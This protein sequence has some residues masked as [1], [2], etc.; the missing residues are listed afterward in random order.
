MKLCISILNARQTTHSNPT[1]YY[2]LIICILFYLHI[3]LFTIIFI[4][5]RFKALIHN[6][7]AQ[8]FCHYAN[9]MVMLKGK[10]LPDGSMVTWKTTQRWVFDSG[11][12]L[13]E[14]FTES[15]LGLD[16]TLKKSALKIKENSFV[17]KSDRPLC[18]SAFEANFS[19]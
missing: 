17:L 4:P 15:E 16:W 13:G 11:G 14:I 18:F 3:I 7:M 12:G 1:A 9:L 5:L 6:F 2:Q 8:Y 10:R 19:V